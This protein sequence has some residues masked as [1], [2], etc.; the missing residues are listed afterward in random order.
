MQFI[1]TPTVTSVFDSKFKTT[2]EH[3]LSWNPQT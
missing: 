1:N 3:E 2:G